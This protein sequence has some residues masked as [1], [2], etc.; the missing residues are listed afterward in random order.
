MMLVKLNDKGVRA[1]MGTGGAGKYCRPR[2]DWQSRTGTIAKYSRNRSLAYVVW[3]GT[4]Y[5]DPVPV[6]LIEPAPSLVPDVAERFDG[7]ADDGKV[8]GTQRN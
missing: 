2:P 6:D 4:R 1:Y 3:D 8:R 7:C 5:F